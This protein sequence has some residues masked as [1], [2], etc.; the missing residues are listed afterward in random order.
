VLKRLA[1]AVRPGIGQDLRTLVRA[2]ARRGSTRALLNAVYHRLPTAAQEAWHGRFADLFRS[3]K[4]AVDAGEW[5]VRFNGRSL[6]LPI[7]PENA[8]LDWDAALSALGHEPEVKQTYAVL[9]QS[10]DRPRVFFDVGANHGLHSLLMLS[11]GVN[12]VSFEPNRDCYDYLRTA[13][14]LNG[15]APTIVQR[16]LGAHRAEVQLSWP[17]RESWLGTTDARVQARVAER[18]EMVVRTV[19]Q[20]TLDEY[21]A[22]SG[23]VPDLIKIDTEGNEPAVIAGASETIR[24]HHPRIIF[25]SWKGPDRVVLDDALRAFGYR[26]AALEFRGKLLIT[27]LDTSAFLGSPATNFLATASR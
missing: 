8:W 4:Y 2:V 14:A 3:G 6:R 10:S 25:E 24:Q 16:A 11:Q 23:L 27:D 1:K 17:A 18:G 22:E 20:I 19:S 9:L 26:I 21:V 13:A 15:S 12:T 5:R 7:R